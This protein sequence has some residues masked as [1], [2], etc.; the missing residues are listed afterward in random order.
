MTMSVNRRSSRDGAM[1][2]GFTTASE[3]AT[4]RAGM[5]LGP[6]LRAGDVIVLSGD[7]GAGKT[8]LVKGVA[9]GLG[10][11]EPV[12]SPTF[13]LLLVHPG[14]LPLYHFDLYRLERMDELEEI[15]YYAVL[16]GDGV[17]MI[18][19]GD[20]F[21]EA[22]PPD[23]LL[24]TIHRSGPEERVFELSASGPRSEALASAWVRALEMG[25]ANG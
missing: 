18:E 15:D 2:S 4:V 6:L 8:Q 21:P 22:L 9:H 24:V 3:V 16:E 7:L 17:S 12:T 10:V 20:R 11:D 19:W 14:E 13:N 5:A 23:H 25:E 1:Q